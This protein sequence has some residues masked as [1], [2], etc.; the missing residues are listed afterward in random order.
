MRVYRIDYTRLVL[1]P[2]NK[3]RE[4]E[5]SMIVCMENMPTETIADP[6][7][8]F[9]TACRKFAYE[10]VKVVSGPTLVHDG[11]VWVQGAV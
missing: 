1:L 9:G 8:E 2:G 10:K 11:P 6:L 7:N 5:F 4:E 3:D